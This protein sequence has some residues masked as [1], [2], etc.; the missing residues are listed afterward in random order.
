MRGRNSQIHDVLCEV[1]K[2]ARER[3]GLSQRAVSALLQRPPNFCHLV[4][5]KRHVL[6]AIEIVRYC[7]V[8][9]TTAA[10]IYTEH[11]GRLILRHS[12]FK[13][14]TPADEYGL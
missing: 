7:A 12:P 10:A 3:A 8:L 9:R 2:E 4:E 5:R 1:L 14:L 6:N 11:E 13:R